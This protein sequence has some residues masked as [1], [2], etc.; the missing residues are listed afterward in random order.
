MASQGICTFS[1]P[2]SHNLVKWSNST[3]AV[4]CLE[5]RSLLQRSGYESVGQITKQG[6]KCN[7]PLWTKRTRPHAAEKSPVA[8]HHTGIFLRL[9]FIKGP[10]IGYYGTYIIAIYKKV[11][12]YCIDLQWPWTMNTKQTCKITIRYH[13]VL[14]GIVIYITT[15]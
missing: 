9:V 8:V 14:Y 12:D 10:P 15:Q 3:R 2:A 5:S 6:K 11:L 1:A 13:T 7:P 4:V